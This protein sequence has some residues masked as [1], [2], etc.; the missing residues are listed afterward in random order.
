MSAGL[1]RPLAADPLAAR[2]LVADGAVTIDARE[3]TLVVK[4]A[5]DARGYAKVLW[6]EGHRA[7]VQ[8]SKRMGR[9]S[10]P[11]CGLP[12][13]GK[14]GSPTGCPATTTQ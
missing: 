8:D 4:P 6:S 7:Q 14:T 10:V 13:L 11:T 9:S 3:R 12:V 1:L 5:R 2:P